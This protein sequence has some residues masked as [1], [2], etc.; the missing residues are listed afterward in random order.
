MIKTKGLRGLL[1]ALI[2]F[3][4]GYAY[5]GQENKYNLS[6]ECGFSE[7]YRDAIAPYWESHGQTGSFKTSD[8][9]KIAYIKF[10]LEDEKG[11]IVIANGRTESYMKYQELVYDL[12]QNGYSVYLLD[13][14]GQGKSDRIL[15]DDRHKGHVD[16]FDDYVDD[17]DKFVKTVVLSRPHNKKYLLAHSM[18]GGIAT[19]YIELHPDVFD[20]AALS[21]PMHAPDAHILVSPEGGCLWFRSMAW[22]CR[23][24]YAGFKARRY[25]ATP[26]AENKYTHSD[27]R[28]ELFR[29]VYSDDEDIQLGGPT[30]GW[31][32]Q[33]CS[34][35][36]DMRKDAGNITIPVLVLQA[37]EDDAVTPKGQQK[38]CESLAEKTG[39]T[40]DGGGPVKF[41]GAYHEL[42]I[43]QD[44]YRIPALTRILDFF[45]AN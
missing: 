25:H 40:C 38:F 36:K 20:A 15:K 29:K 39:T 8:G 31:A 11:A 21:S 37:G 30:R 45:A 41:E 4:A 22:M 5:A 17:L 6:T 2:T 35:S 43:E 10:E 24:C 14:R 9:L 32:A 23:D 16:Q 27:V 26:F 3:I 44:K 13:H 18:G 12:A 42:F 28:Y 7:R 33:A 1:L 34:A 19:R